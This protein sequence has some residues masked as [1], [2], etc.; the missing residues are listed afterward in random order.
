MS[1]SQPGRREQGVDGLP[2]RAI[3]ERVDHR[4]KLPVRRRSAR[5]LVLA[6]LA[7]R[8]HE[9]LAVRERSARPFGTSRFCSCLKRCPPASPGKAPVPPWRSSRLNCGAVREHELACAQPLVYPAVGPPKEGGRLPLRVG[10]LNPVCGDE[11]GGLGCH[12]RNLLRGLA[13]GG[14]RELRTT[15]THSGGNQTGSQS[16]NTCL[17]HLVPMR[18]GIQAPGGSGTQGCELR[19]C[20]TR[21][22]RTCAVSSDKVPAGFRVT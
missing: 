14:T 5:D 19:F 1:G 16:K 22:R 17:K 6:G 20:L 10:R 2:V 13:F 4:H 7:M 9:Q 18:E 8:G 12:S 11:C 15:Y 3:P 21:L